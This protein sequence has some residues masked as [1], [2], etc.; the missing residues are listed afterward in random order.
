MSE[1]QYRVE[2]FIG[3]NA[4]VVVRVQRRVFPDEPYGSWKTVEHRGGLEQT[5]IGAPTFTGHWAQALFEWRVNRAVKKANL[6]IESYKAGDS[7]R[8]KQI[9]L[10]YV[11]LK[12][13]G[14]LVER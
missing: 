11:A 8:L 4:E 7:I 12:K 1:Y 14:H 13:A 9:E 3:D 2:T 10:S 5:I 6:A